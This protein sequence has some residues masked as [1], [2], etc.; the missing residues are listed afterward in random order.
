MICFDNAV[1][2][3]QFAEYLD[4]NKQ[5]VV[6]MQLLTVNP[7]AIKGLKAWEITD[8]F[9]N[10]WEVIF[11]ENFNEWTIAGHANYCPFR[12]FVHMADSHVEIHTAHRNGKVIKAD[13]MLQKYINLASIV[14][15]YMRF[16]Y[17]KV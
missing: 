10:C 3:E 17:F 2:N 16:G 14:N 13:R 4:F 1:T 6:P 7:D 12:V 8:K 15:C 5:K 9:D 11:N